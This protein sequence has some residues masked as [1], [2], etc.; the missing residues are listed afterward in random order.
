V[1]KSDIRLPF[2]CVLSLKRA[3]LRDGEIRLKKP[4]ARLDWSSAN[5]VATLSP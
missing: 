5:V 2:S 1:T 3:L 4:L